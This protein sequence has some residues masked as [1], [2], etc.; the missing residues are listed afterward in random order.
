M[1]ERLEL[2]RSGV[3]VVDD[4]PAMLRNFRRA[5]DEHGY[6]IE[7][8]QSAAEAES[9]LARA[10]FDVCLLDVNLGEDSGMDLLPRLREAAPW[11][12]I[13]MATALNDATLAVNALRTGASD[14]LVKPCSPDELVH[15]VAQQADARRMERRIEALEKSDDDGRSEIDLD[16]RNPQLLATYEVARQVAA[17]DATVLIL[18]ESGVG[19]NVLAR[20]IHDWS[21]RSKGNFATVSCPSLSA[22]LLASELFGHVRGAFTG[23]TDNRQGRVQVADGGTLFL[24]EI[25]DMPAAMQPR[26]LRFIQDREYERVGDPHTRKAD[27]RVIAATNHDLR[28]MV[29]EGRFREDLYYRLNVVTLTMPSLRERR[30]DVAR[31]ATHLLE[32]FVHQ[33]DRPA[34]RF[35]EA[36][37][38]LL[39][40]YDWPGNLRELRNV[41][42]RAVILCPGDAVGPEHLPFASSGRGVSGGLRA[43]DPVSL[44]E[45]EQAHI[46]ALLAISPTME[47]AART[48]GIDSSTLYRKRKQYNMP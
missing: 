21:V 43:G 3:L 15:A 4:D 42:E 31:L 10:V 34:R 8:A 32:K 18:G 5:L 19:K 35:G 9:A 41:V 22:E 7:T 20:A 25:G 13:V 14:Y 46:Q 27:V 11:M 6:R 38:A 29:S 26:L 39:T 12:R 37:T 1:S 16:T 47:A 30:E 45:L 36:A 17:T 23:A 48:L 24:D 44:Q 40:A 2:Q 33:Y 28:A